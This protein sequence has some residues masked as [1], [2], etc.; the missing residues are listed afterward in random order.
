MID[1]IIQSVGQFKICLEV[2]P[3]H[4]HRLY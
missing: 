3:Q 1:V 2:P 4:D